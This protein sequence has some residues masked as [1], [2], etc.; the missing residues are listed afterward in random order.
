MQTNYKKKKK[1]IPEK[2][3][4]Q[5]NKID[6]FREKKDK[7]LKRKGSGTG[8]TA[9]ERQALC[10]MYETHINYLEGPLTAE[11]KAKAENAIA[12]SRLTGEGAKQ[13]AESASMFTY[14]FC[15]LCL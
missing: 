7:I 2:I 6:F 1:R 13:A 15:C 10:R 9:A 5:T 11:A 12:S 14:I 8:K 4:E 3:A